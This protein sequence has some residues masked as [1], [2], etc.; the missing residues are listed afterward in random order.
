MS[1]LNIVGHAT[2]EPSSFSE[3]VYQGT[4]GPGLGTAAFSICCPDDH[5]GRLQELSKGA[6]SR[7]VEKTLCYV[8]LIPR[9]RG[10]W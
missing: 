2:L 9:R 6:A 1:I 10:G 7:H 4:R 8:S 3:A 5:D